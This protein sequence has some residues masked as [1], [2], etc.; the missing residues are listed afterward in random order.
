MTEKTRVHLCGATLICP[1][2]A[3][4]VRNLPPTDMAPGYARPDFSHHDG[5]TLC[6]VFSHGFASHLSGRM[7]AAPVAFLPVTAVPRT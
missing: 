1:E 4:G 6:P 7:P 2:C 3:E 5:S